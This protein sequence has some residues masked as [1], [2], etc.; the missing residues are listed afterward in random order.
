MVSLSKKL[1]APIIR[2]SIPISKP[3]K[4][5]DEQIPFIPFSKLQEIKHLESQL[6]STLEEC[7]NLAQIKQTHSYIIRKCLHQSSYIMAKLLRMLSKINVSMESYG[8]RVFSQ[9]RYPN[10]FLYTALIRG[11][12]VDGMFGE[13]VLVYNSMR[14]DGLVPVTFTFTALLKVAASEMNVNLGRQLHGESM[15]LGG[16]SEDLFVGNAST[17]FSNDEERERTL[18]TS[19]AVPPRENYVKPRLPYTFAVERT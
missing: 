5:P 4:F 18:S 3:I 9:V 8:G 14:K 19:A 12:L 15:K 7:R 10:A 1:I 17:I 13:S 6:I 11:Y 2:A 16:F